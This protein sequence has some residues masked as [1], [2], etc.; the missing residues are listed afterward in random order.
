[1]RKVCLLAVLAA[2][3]GIAA[4]PATAATWTVWA[5]APSKP[6]A[7]IPKSLLLDQFF[8]KTLTVH[9]GDRVTFQSKNFHTATFPGKTPP[10]KLPLIVPGANEQYPQILDGAGTPFFFSGMQKFIYNPQDVYPAGSRRIADAGFHGSGI[11]L[12]LKRGWTVTF[13]KP[14]AYKFI[15][16]VHPGMKGTILVKP[17]GAPTKTQSQVQALVAQQLSKAFATAKTQFESTRPSAPN[18][19]IAG[20]GSAV[21]N[22]S[23]FPEKLTVPVGTTVTFVNDR[24][25]SEPHNVAFGPQSYIL[26]DFLKNTDLLGPPGTPDQFSPAFVYG[27][28]P[29]GKYVYEGTSHGN[30]FLATFVIDDEPASPPP[31][32]LQ[33]TFTKPGSYHYLCMIH[34]PDMA[35]DIVV[36]G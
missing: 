14:G 30:G 8:P 9:A 4:S 36:A 19:V 25:P 24:N 27:T 6:P 34:G 28:E 32:S 17:K 10:A 21:A 12:F 7:G 5:D 23:F 13:P 2:A 35:G 33:I 3:A 29:G 20:A 16:T 26:D 22:L 18:T 31:Q 15:C 1:M 11:L